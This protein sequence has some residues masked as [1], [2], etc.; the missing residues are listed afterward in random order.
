MEEAKRI[1]ST[2]DL[3]LTRQQVDLWFQQTQKEG[4]GTTENVKRWRTGNGS[5]N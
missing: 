5:E 2:N 3:G 4:N 1:L